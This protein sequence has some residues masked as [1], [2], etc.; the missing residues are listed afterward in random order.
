M[1]GLK[2]VI[3]GG[4]A[5][6]GALLAEMVVAEGAGGVGIID[7]N[8]VAADAAL[9]PARSARSRIASYGLACSAPIAGRVPMWERCDNAQISR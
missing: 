9:A 2:V 4:G 1:K 8:A 6:L 7:I 3:V 5:G